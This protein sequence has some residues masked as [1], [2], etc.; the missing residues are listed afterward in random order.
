V[1]TP[2]QERYWAKLRAIGYGFL[3]PVFFVMTGVQFD[4]RA[5]FAHPGSLA[6]MPLARWRRGARRRCVPSEPATGGGFR[7]V[8]PRGQQL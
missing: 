6:L 5:L 2:S 8:A 3:V 4:V 7:G 1:P